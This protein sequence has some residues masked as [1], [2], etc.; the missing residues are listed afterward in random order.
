MNHN[1]FK[2]RQQIE[3]IRKNLP[4][5]VSKHLIKHFLIYSPQEDEQYFIYVMEKMR[6]MNKTEEQIL[7]QGNLNLIM[8]SAIIKQMTEPEVFYDTVKIF[9]DTHSDAK[10]LFSVLPKLKNIYLNGLGMELPNIG[11]MLKIIASDMF[12]FNVHELVRPFADHLNQ[13]IFGNHIW[14]H[15][16]KIKET[17]PE[18]DPREIVSGLKYMLTQAITK[19]VDDISG[20]R[21]QGTKNK[22]VQIDTKKAFEKQKS[23]IDALEYLAEHYNIHWADL[24]DENV[25]I[26]PSDR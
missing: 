16:D 6:E 4:E 26:R 3:Q 14:K 13:K 5:E 22:H 10:Y 21:F 1:E 23:F 19:I 2:V 17:D 25:M 12:Y 20:P 8:P 15:W 24:H 7:Y 18:H 9:L 11:Q